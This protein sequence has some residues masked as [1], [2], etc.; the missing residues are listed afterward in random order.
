MYFHPQY[1]GYCTEMVGTSQRTPLDARESNEFGSPRIMLV[2][3]NNQKAF[4][5]QS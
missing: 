5:T 2:A 3:M 1:I 4:M